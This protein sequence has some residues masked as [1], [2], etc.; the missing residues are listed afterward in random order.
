[1]N[2]EP[3]VTGEIYHIYNRGADKRDI[4]LDD[5]DYKR[6]IRGLLL[7]N[8]KNAVSLRALKESNTEVAPPKPDEKLVSVLAYCLMPNHYHLLVQET[9]KNG[10]TRFMRKLGTGYT[11]YFN[12]RNERNGVLYQGQFKSV[13]IDKDSYLQYIPHYI[14]LNPLDLIMSW[15]EGEVDPK[16]ATLFLDSY[17]WSSYAHYVKRKPNLVLDTDSIQ[18]LYKLKE[19]WNDLFEWLKASELERVKDVALE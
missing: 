19:Y 8:N 10:I 9:E 16:K 18:E 15:R 11:M 7:F 6:F 17:K 3:F 13:L 2:R 12:T 4:F 1:M 14:H 5:N